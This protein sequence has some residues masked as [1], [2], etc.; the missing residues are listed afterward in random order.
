MYR[1]HVCDTTRG[2]SKALL[3]PDT[4]FGMPSNPNTML[5]QRIF[6]A[7]LR[8]KGVQEA[9]VELSMAPNLSILN[10]TIDSLK[11]YQHGAIITSV[12]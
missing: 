6:F 12:K 2:S 3:M 8:Y 1:S 11:A 4:E 9:P 7:M 10:I 5:L